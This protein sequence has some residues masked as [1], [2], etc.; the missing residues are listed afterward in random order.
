MFSTKQ[1]VGMQPIVWTRDSRGGP[2]YE[3]RAVGRVVRTGA[4]RVTVQV[5]RA[6]DEAWV[7]R[8]VGPHELEVATGTDLKRLEALERQEQRS[9][10]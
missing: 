6:S 3:D 10:A 7:I 1:L 8:S 9:A 4:G 5:F 2:G